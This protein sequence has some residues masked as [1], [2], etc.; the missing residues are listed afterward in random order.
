MSDDEWEL[1]LLLFE[2]EAERQR[3]KYSVTIRQDH[4]NIDRTG[5]LC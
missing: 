4:C 2:L 5:W 3:A 1:K